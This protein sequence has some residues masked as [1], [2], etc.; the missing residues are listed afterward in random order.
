M[1]LTAAA[2]TAC[3]LDNTDSRASAT[4]EALRTVSAGQDTAGGTPVDGT[5]K[6]QKPESGST[7]SVDTSPDKK[8]S[9]PKPLTEAEEKQLLQLVRCG[10]EPGYHTQEALHD[11]AK[12]CIELY[13]ESMIGI[14]DYAGISPEHVDG[15]M[16]STEELMGK[17]TNGLIEAKFVYVEPSSDAVAKLEESIV[18]GCS[19]AI[20]GNP[21]DSPAQIAGGTMPLNEFDKLIG[22]DDS[23]SCVDGIYGLA[24]DYGDYRYGDVFEATERSGYPNAHTEAVLL[25]EVLHLYGLN[26]SSGMIAKNGLVGMLDYYPEDGAAIDLSAYLADVEYYEYGPLSGLGESSVMGGPQPNLYTETELSTREWHR[27]ELPFRVL[28]V[29]PES[30]PLTRADDLNSKGHIEYSE[31]DAGRNFARYRLPEEIVLSPERSPERGSHQQAFSDLVFT[32]AKDSDTGKL[33][34]N[35]GLEAEDGTYATIWRIPDEVN[36]GLTLSDG[37]VLRVI[38]GNKLLTVHT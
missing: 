27:L 15:F 25:H 11:A 7:D 9:E 1:L 21:E 33:G 36:F 10:H 29:E 30:G 26:H 5:L 32:P 16:R 3:G 38:Y 17:L 6:T 2:L 18:D 31:A 13:R 28:G 23:P 35:I 12:A 22:L 14:V 37:T 8:S 24:F 34:L 4:D 19:N 20:H